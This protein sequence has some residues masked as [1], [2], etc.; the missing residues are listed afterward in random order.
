MSNLHLPMHD[1]EYEWIGDK[2]FTVCTM[3][4]IVTHTIGMDSKDTYT[5]NGKKYYKPYRNH[6]NTRLGEHPW[7]ELEAA[8][9]AA[10]GKV[11]VRDNGNTKMTDYYM[12]RKGLDWM[13]EELG[14]IIRD[15]R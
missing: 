2:R 15:E 14:I 7:P 12:T 9:Y 11:Y 5:R 3:R 6:F 13:G 8:G 4:Q 10:H 1:Y